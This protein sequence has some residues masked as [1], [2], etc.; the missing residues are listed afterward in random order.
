MDLVGDNMAEDTMTLE[1]MTSI[2]K[3]YRLLCEDKD[4][5]IMYLRKQLESLK[6]RLDKATSGGVAVLEWEA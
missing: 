3:S 1:Q 5:E 4:K 6:S 2:M